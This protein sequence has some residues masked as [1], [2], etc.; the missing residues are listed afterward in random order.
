MRQPSSSQPE[1]EVAAAVL[2]VQHHVAPKVQH[3]ATN[4]E[5]SCST[6]AQPHAGPLMIT[7]PGR[8]LLAQTAQ[9]STPRLHTGSW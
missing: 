4:M 8:V 9:V 3:H 2:Q 5:P 6:N 7:T 1:E